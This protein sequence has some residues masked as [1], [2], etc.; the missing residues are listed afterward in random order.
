MQGQITVA[1]TTPLSSGS[2]LHKETRAQRSQKKEVQGK[3]RGPRKKEKNRK[4]ERI[5]YAVNIYLSVKVGLEEGLHGDSVGALVLLEGRIDDVQVILDLLAGS[6]DAV[7]ERQRELG[8][9]GEVGSK[10]GQSKTNDQK[11]E[12][13]ERQLKQGDNHEWSTED[14]SGEMEIVEGLESSDLDREI[15]VLDAWVGGLLPACAGLDG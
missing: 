8:S 15:R 3:P 13:P 14:D 4:L 12:R 9:I 6:L 2:T 1:L 7:V 10:D 11:R 5:I